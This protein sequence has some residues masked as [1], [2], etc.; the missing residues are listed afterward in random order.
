MS[1]KPLAADLQH[2]QT[3]AAALISRLLPGIPNICPQA[4]AARIKIN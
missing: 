1:A 4:Q 2:Y 3:R